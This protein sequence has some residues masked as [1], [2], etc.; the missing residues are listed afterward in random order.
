MWQREYSAVLTACYTALYWRSTG[1]WGSRRRAPGGHGVVEV[2]LVLYGTIHRALT[3][4]HITHG[5]HI[6]TAPF[7]RGIARRTAEHAARACRGM[8]RKGTRGVVVEDTQRVLT[9]THSSGE[10]ASGSRGRK[11]A[12]QQ[13]LHGCVGPTG[14]WLVGCTHGVRAFGVHT[15][16]CTGARASVGCFLHAIRVRTCRAE[17]GSA[18]HGVHRLAWDSLHYSVWMGYPQGSFASTWELKRTRH[19]LGTLCGG[20]GRSM[21][22]ARNVSSCAQRRH[23]FRR[24]RPRR[25]TSATPTRPR[26]RRPPPRRRVGRTLPT[27][28]V[29]AMRSTLARSPSLPLC[30]CPRALQTFAPTGKSDARAMLPHP[31]TPPPPP[32]TPSPPVRRA[33]YC[34]WRRACSGPAHS[35]AAALT[36]G[37][38][39]APLRHA[40]AAAGPRGYSDSTMPSGTPP[41]CIRQSWAG[42][43]RPARVL[44]RTH[45]DCGTDCATPRSTGPGLRPAL[46]RVLEGTLEYS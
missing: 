5:C 2:W 8:A 15:V 25:P 6:A 9:G 17:S 37:W 36:H 24:A 44:R 13:A 34:V 35:R 29:R 18:S 26:A 16:Y 42:A 22:L 19:C 38:Y 14:I 41:P 30:R 1:R 33:A 10:S 31:P 46:D 43:A 12:T 32:P 4:R 11:R 28:R 23:L 20:S 39:A 27:R 7:W 21:P 40:A 3:M 45:A